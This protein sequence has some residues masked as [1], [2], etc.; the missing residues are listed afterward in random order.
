MSCS[1]TS[2]VCRRGRQQNGGLRFGRRILLSAGLFLAIVAFGGGKDFDSFFV[3]THFKGAVDWSQV[4]P[5]R[6]VRTDGSEE[7]V[8]VPVEAKLAS[9]DKGLCG[10][11]VQRGK[12]LA[13]AAKGLWRNDTVEVL[14]L[15]GTTRDVLHHFAYDPC[16]NTFGVRARRHPVPGPDES[17]KPSA[18]VSNTVEETAWTSTF[19]IPFDDFIVG[20][21]ERPA[22]GVRW[23][24]NLVVTKLGDAVQRLGTAATCGD[25]RN[26]R[27][28]AAIA[29]SEDRWTPPAAET[30]R[31]M[32]AADG[33]R[34]RLG[35]LSDV[36][37]VGSR[38]VALLKKALGRFRDEKVAGVVIAGDIADSGFAEELALCA[39]AWRAVF[40]NDRGADGKKVEKLF[41]YGNHD[42]DRWTWQ[43]KPE[44]LKDPAYRARSIGADDNRGRMWERTF[45]EPYAPVWMKD[46][47]GYKVIGVHWNCCTNL[48]DFLAAH[49]AE[50]KGAKPFFV[51][52]HPHPK[53]T[54]IGPWAWGAE[55]DGITEALAKYPNAV[56]ISGHSHS[57][58]S[59][60]RSVWR[61]AFT[62]INASSLGS[63]IGDYNLRDNIGGNLFGYAGL[64]RKKLSPRFIASDAH[65]GL[66]LS[67]TDETLRLKRIS[68]TYGEDVGPDWIV[69]LDPAKGREAM[70]VAQRRARRPAPVFTAE[71]SVAVSRPSPDRLWV[72]FPAAKTVGEASVWEYEVTGVLVEDGVEL[73]LVTKRLFAPDH[74]LP[75]SRKGEGCACVFA[76]DDFPPNGHIRFDVRPLE[77]LGNAGRAISSELFCITK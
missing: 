48:A 22:P 45:G 12:P 75:E 52:T 51:I 10:R 14:A 2:R 73:P 39:E 15:P 29:F 36:H 28:Y 46:V 72:A 24:L 59:D 49:D 66:L 47:G 77:S 67:L 21:G 11:I 60:E 38:D 1:W 34:L 13:D 27:L 63:A 6:L 32:V 37:L 42:I 69:P 62:A 17:W 43:K 4:E 7:P 74:F 33:E 71:A 18:A 31:T 20:P 53:N 23:H 9:T 35:V 68:F 50:L 55:K 8:T 41:I 19:F 30:V 5:V 26:A 70:G 54:C 61:G 76:A 56:S 57:P 3:V 16:G 44:A 25:S 40:P 64:A 58:L 65:E